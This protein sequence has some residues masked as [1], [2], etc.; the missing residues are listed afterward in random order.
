M[1]EPL[2]ERALRKRRESKLET[3]R[4]S[5]PRV[6][7]NAGKQHGEK[8]RAGQELA[9]ARGVLFGRPKNPKLTPETLERARA[10]LVNGMRLREVAMSLRVPITT[11]HRALP[12]VAKR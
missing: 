3:E 9:R 7:R 8:I 12:G 11:L 1:T 6:R 4:E 2:W 5:K 10:M